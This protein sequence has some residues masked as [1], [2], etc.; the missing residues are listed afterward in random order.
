[1][2]APPSLIGY[3]LSATLSVSQNAYSSR[4]VLWPWASK[5]GAKRVQTLAEVKG[6][7]PLN[8]MSE[9]M[10]ALYTI[11]NVLQAKLDRPY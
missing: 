2:S 11:L 6:E 10:D 4:V 8:Q 3:T 1:M 5:K 9:G 7:F